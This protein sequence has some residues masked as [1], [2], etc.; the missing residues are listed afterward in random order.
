MSYTI[1]DFGIATYNNFLPYGRLKVSTARSSWIV[2]LAEAKAHLRIES[3]Y[4]VDDTY[5]TLLL[6]IAQDIVEKETSLLLSAVGITYIADG[7]LPV[8]DLGVNGSAVASVKYYDTANAQ[9]TLAVNTDY[10][11]SNLSYLNESIRIYP[12]TNNN[13]PDTFDKP[14]SVEVIFTAGCS[15]NDVPLGL[16]QATLLI[17]GRYYEM[18]QDVGTGMF[19]I[20]KGAT[21]L[22]N[23]YNRAT[24]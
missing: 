13:W 14:D 23:Q 20:P 7:F 10:Y 18:R 19:D 9:Q 8:I 3:G 15:T 2:S 11:V 12:S 16:Y 1:N 5:I 21:H 22:I 24:I 17:I 4:T 6:K